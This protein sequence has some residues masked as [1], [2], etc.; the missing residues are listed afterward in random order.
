L[1]RVALVGS[2]ALLIVFAAANWRKPGFWALGLGL[3]LNFLVIV[4]N[5]GLMPI[6]PHLLER[7][8]GPSS[9]GLWQVGE[10]MGYSKDIIL[11]ISETRLWWLSDRFTL[12]EWSPYKVAFSV[13][14]IIIGLGAFLLFWSLGG[15]EKSPEGGQQ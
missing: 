10:R 6:S 12:P 15:P 8:L 4:L 14:D 1:A 2:Q 5:G 7:Y 13:G 11:P 9:T 3:I